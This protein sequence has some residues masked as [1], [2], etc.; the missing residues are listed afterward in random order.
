MSGKLSTITSSIVEEN[1]VA[2]WKILIQIFIDEYV[3]HFAHLL[4]MA[5]ERENVNCQYIVRRS[6]IGSI[7]IMLIEGS[8]VR[9]GNW[10]AGL[11]RRVCS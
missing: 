2:F 4:V 1:G 7:L 11:Y 9:A 6:K 3:V 8:I 5:F 10:V